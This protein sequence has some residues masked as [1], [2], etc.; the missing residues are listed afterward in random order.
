MKGGAVVLVTR[1]GAAE[2]SRTAA[3]ALACAGSEPDRAGLLVDLDAQRRPRPSLVATAA[4][5]R[6]EER[7]AAHLP[8]A[9]VASRGC[10]CH[11]TLATGSEPTGLLPSA[12]ALVRDSTA[13]VHLPPSLLQPALEQRD[14]GARAV[15]LRAD[16]KAD[17][18]LTALAASD[19]IERRLRVAVLKR[20]P[21]W[22]AGRAALFGVLPSGDLALPSRVVGRVL[23]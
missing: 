14:I 8:E 20:Q 2:G 13:V 1:V 17:R 16:P 19:L 18:S 11:L 23:G 21:G 4:A 6:L 22:A 12:L 9:A 7:L 3:A 10:T 15:L 5:R